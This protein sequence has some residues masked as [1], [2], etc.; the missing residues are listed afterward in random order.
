M[1]PTP[2]ASAPSVSALR[3]SS[4]KLAISSKPKTSRSSGPNSTTPSAT[5]ARHIGKIVRCAL[6]KRSPNSLAKL[7]RNDLWLA[8]SE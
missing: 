1:T 5:L 7:A 4:G 8:P 3:F 6:G 2:T